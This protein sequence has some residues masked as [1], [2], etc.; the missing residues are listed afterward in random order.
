MVVFFFFVVCLFPSSLNYTR[1]SEKGGGGEG[2]DMKE[3][4]SLFV[5]VVG[6]SFCCY[7]CWQY[8]VYRR[9]KIVFFA[10]NFFAFHEYL[11]YIP[12]SCFVGILT[13]SP[14]SYAS[15]CIFV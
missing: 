3:S 12:L 8:S 7:Q 9:T 10:H 13:P 6:L 11:I 5:Y 15:T 4:W 14:F 2:I 1:L